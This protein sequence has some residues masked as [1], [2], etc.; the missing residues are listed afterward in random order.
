MLR[1]ASVVLPPEHQEEEMPKDERRSILRRKLRRATK[2]AAWLVPNVL[3]PRSS[4]I[5]GRGIIMFGLTKSRLDAFHRLFHSDDQGIVRDR[6]V[7]GVRTI[8]HDLDRERLYDV[9]QV[10]DEMDLDDSGRV[11]W[12]QFT[13]FLARVAALRRHVSASAEIKFFL[14]SDSRVVRV[15]SC[16]HSKARQKKIRNFLHFFLIFF[17]FFFV[18]WFSGFRIF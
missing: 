4:A 8:F 3:N 9:Q 15:R 6:F 10:F 7:A 2:K 1:S 16:D 5:R 11:R 13:T 14:F 12:D 18:F 17:L